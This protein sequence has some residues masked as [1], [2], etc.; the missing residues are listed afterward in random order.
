MERLLLKSPSVVGA[1]VTFIVHVAPAERLEPQVLVWVKGSATPIP[2]RRRAAE[3][4][5]LNVMAC[6]ALAV[7]TPW[8]PNEM[9]RTDNVV[10]GDPLTDK[11]AVGDPPQAPQKSM[12]QT[13][14]EKYLFMVSLS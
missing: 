7:P 13:A 14:S 9:L 1:N 4:V 2:M 10:L 11:L 6:P 5:L 3:P 12:P 8:L